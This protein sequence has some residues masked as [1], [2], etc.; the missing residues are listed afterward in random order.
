MWI[1]T[2]MYN[3]KQ[4]KIQDFK[5]VLILIPRRYIYSINL[6]NE[7]VYFTV[8]KYTPKKAYL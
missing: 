4:S 1:Q 8:K 5:H 7:S 2:A 3:I 6:N